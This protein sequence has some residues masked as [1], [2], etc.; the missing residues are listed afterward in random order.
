MIALHFG[1]GAVEAEFWRWLFVMARIGAALT[2]APLFGGA[3]VPPQVRVI[4]AGAVAALVCT[5]TSVQPPEALFSLPG[6]I[7]ILGEIVV[8]LSL[9]FALQIAFAAPTIAAEV[10]GGGMGL[11]I[12]ATVDPENGTHSAVLGQY[13]TVVLTLVFLGLGGHLQWLA[14]VVKS[15]S[16]FPPGAVF[17][18]HGFGA[19][20]F[21]A[22]TGFGSAMFVTAAVIALPVSLVLLLV[23]VLA[24]VLSRAAPAL[25]LFSL[26][27]PAGIIAGVAAL[28][29]S[30]PLMSER[31][32]ALS[33]DAIAQAE[34]V[35]AK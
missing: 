33:A 5:W 3:S 2:A 19:E 35:I 18:A 20:R 4:L 17:A 30:A 24:G 12:A 14:L 31:M 23:Q 34:Q 15:Y 11:S 21:A 9:G 16:V 29:A 28:I 32:T 6:V 25:N 13:Y 1:F 27:L 7:A 26:G 10:I 22:I 8:G